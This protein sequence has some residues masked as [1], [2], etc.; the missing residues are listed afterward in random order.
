MQ[1]SPEH[2]N[3]KGAFY[4]PPPVEA[5]PWKSR[6]SKWGSSTY[7]SRYSS[8]YSSWDAAR[9]SG[10][11]TIKYTESELRGADKAKF[12]KCFNGLGRARKDFSDPPDKV[13]KAALLQNRLSAVA[14]RNALEA[15]FPKYWSDF[16]LSGVS[17]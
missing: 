13:I 15:W 2:A 6:Y 4:V 5:Q 16:D 11:A 7:S 14:A 1:A 17:N 12:D 3:R 10:P 9:S 8:P